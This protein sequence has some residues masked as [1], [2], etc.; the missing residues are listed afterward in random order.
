M[1]IARVQPTNSPDRKIILENLLVTLRGLALKEGASECAVLD[2]GDLQ[3]KEVPSDAP[4]VPDEQN[5]LFWPVPKFPRDSICD[6]LK[7]YDRAMVFRVDIDS[8]TPPS[9]AREKVFKIAGLLE[10]ACFYGGSHLSISLAAGN[11]KDVFCETEPRCEALKTGKPCLHPLKSRA[12]LEACGIDPAEI[13]KKA[14]WAESG[15]DDIFVGMVFV[16]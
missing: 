13:A 12:S 1:E 14:G 8:E 5:S 11:C 7:Q 16:S 3:F 6:G 9:A 4:D 2:C 15:R 10:S